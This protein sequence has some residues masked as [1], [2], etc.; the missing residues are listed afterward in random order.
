MKNQVNEQIQARKVRAELRM[1]HAR[2]LSDNVNQICRFF[3][4]SRALFYI[5]K[6]RFEKDGLAGFRDQP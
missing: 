4:V 6:N 1:H 2:R 3:G 5:R